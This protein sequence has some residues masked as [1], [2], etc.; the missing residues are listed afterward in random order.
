VPNKKSEGKGKNVWHFIVSGT[1][2]CLSLY[3][4]W[5]FIVLFIALHFIVRYCTLSVALSA[6]TDKI[7]SGRSVAKATTT[8]TRL[9]VLPSTQTRLS[10]LPSTQTRLSVL[11][12]PKNGS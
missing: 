2:L 7:V 1:L 8:Q 10:V 6:T 5:H 11:H 3:S 12:Y 9:S 4:A